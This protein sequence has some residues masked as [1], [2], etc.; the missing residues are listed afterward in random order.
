M[1]ENANLFTGQHGSIRIIQWTSLPE[2]A[3]PPI[4]NAERN[5]R[6]AGGILEGSMFFLPS[7]LDI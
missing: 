5:F 2:L 1:D 4:P 7:T 3:P 6:M